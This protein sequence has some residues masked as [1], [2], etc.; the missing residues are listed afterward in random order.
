MS[1]NGKQRRLCYWK[2]SSYFHDHDCYPQNR[3]KKE[4]EYKALPS[5][6][7]WL[8]RRRFKEEENKGAEKS[9]SYTGFPPKSDLLQNAVKAR[10]TFEERMEEYRKAINVANPDGGLLA[11][12]KQLESEEQ[13]NKVYDELVRASGATDD[14]AAGLKRQWTESTGKCIEILPRLGL[15]ACATVFEAFV[16]DMFK[17]SFNTMFSTRTVNESDETYWYSWLNRRAFE[18]L[19][20]RWSE[21]EHQRE[22]D[23]WEN[24]EPTKDENRQ[25]MKEKAR[26]R[27]NYQKLITLRPNT[28]LIDL[29]R[30]ESWPEI[31]QHLKK[32][33]LSQEAIGLVQEMVDTRKKDVMQNVSNTTMDSI[34]EGFLRLV[35]SD[36]R[37]TR[38]R[39]GKKSQTSRSGDTKRPREEEEQPSTS[40]P[41]SYD[42]PSDIA[43]PSVSI[44]TPPITST[45]LSAAGGSYK[46]PETGTTRARSNEETAIEHLISY[47]C[48]R[49]KNKLQ[50]SIGGSVYDV[51]CGDAKTLSYMLNLFYGLRSIFCHGS[52]EATTIFGAMRADRT[53]SMP[54]DLNIIMHETDATK[55]L[56]MVEARESE[57]KT[58]LFGLF[59]TANKDL[60]RMKVDYDLFLTAQSFYAYAVKV[61]G[62]VAACIAYRYSDIKLKE[63]AGDAGECAFEKIEAA[64]TTVHTQINARKSSPSRFSESQSVSGTAEK[65]ET[66]Q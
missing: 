8:I 13:L 49:R 41:M 30:K 52:P 22:T 44:G 47:Y 29:I 24:F 3:D 35:K 19:G 51:K 31:Y 37:G 15:V 21:E 16:H 53:P 55:E 59:T 12:L 48:G 1:T 46:S 34:V 9:A 45:P 33:P 27:Q 20:L 18:S 11:T 17:R 4:A 26:C 7:V 56:Q 6:V 60:N 39:P 23:F 65:M 32:D 36:E 40:S 50:M 10:E 58:H 14:K 62:S 43:D 5:C 25:K 66:Q 57:C 2:A 54:S 38:K 63:K 42:T 61:I 64:W 28:M